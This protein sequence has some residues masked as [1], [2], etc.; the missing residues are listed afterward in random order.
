MWSSLM[1]RIR[2]GGMRSEADVWVGGLKYTILNC[3]SL[4]E[5]GIYD[6]TD[7]AFG[8]RIFNSHCKV[9]IAC[10]RRDN[11]IMLVALKQANKSDGNDREKVYQ[12]MKYL[13]QWNT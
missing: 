7:V 6:Y 11:G 1:E 12:F 10:D 4:F 13:V 9:H 3:S 5:Y 2:S 8:V